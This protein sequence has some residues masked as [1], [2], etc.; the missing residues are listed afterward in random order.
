MAAPP[1]TMTQF[2]QS[3]GKGPS[4]FQ[5]YL[6][7]YTNLVGGLL[8]H[9]FGGTP[10]PHPAAHA[11]QAPYNPLA[12]TP[13]AQE[14]PMLTN[15]VH[16]QIAPLIAQTNQTY[17]R[18]AANTRAA[19]TQYSKALAGFYQPQ[20]SNAQ[21][22]GSAVNNALSGMQAFAQNGA[23][24]TG[25]AANIVPQFASNQADRAAGLSSALTAYRSTLPAFAADTGRFTLGA[26][27]GKI[28]SDRSAA[29]DKI[30]A[31]EPGLFS[32]LYQAYQAQEI[33]KALA[34]STV[35]YKSTT[36]SA[37]KTRAAAAVTNANAN[38]AK[39]AASAAAKTQAAADKRHK[40]YL[41]ATAKATGIA[42][43]EIDKAVAAQ[44]IPGKPADF[45]GLKIP[46]K[47]TKGRVA[48]YYGTIHRIESLLQPVLGEYMGPRDITR[49]VQRLVNGAYAAGQ[50][51]RP[52]AGTKKKAA[53]PDTSVLFQ[54]WWHLP[55]TGP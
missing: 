42:K 14:Q 20:A 21:A 10:T 23:G 35:G 26:D 34:A 47:S 15:L 39:A 48:N 22:V 45:G 41:A 28:N 55:A 27:L 53:A 50:Y 1:M 25:A 44:T 7:T 11:P 30:N 5:K 2:F 6:H 12:P 49:F 13:W 46:T 33:N 29:I 8:H 31:Q 24:L 52:G 54:P 9:T 19:L 4:A 18:Q 3:T 17:D 38:A 51:G 40:A 43:S 37:A 36:A 16:S 32:K